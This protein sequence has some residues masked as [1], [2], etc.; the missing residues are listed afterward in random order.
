MNISRNDLFIRPLGVRT[1]SP[2]G[3]LLPWVK[4]TDRYA[5]PNDR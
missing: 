2:G 4:P 1:S 3:R 5:P